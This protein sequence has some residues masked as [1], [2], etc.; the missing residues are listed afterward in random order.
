MSDA[1]SKSTEFSSA[2]EKNDR[3]AMTILSPE[4]RKSCETPSKT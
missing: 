2:L 1:E 4:A 3:M